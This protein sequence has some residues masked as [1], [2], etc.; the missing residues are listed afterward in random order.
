MKKK[1]TYKDIKN[2]KEH[3]ILS[4]VLFVIVFIIFL[5]SYKAFLE[6]IGTTDE[7]AYVE[8]SSNISFN[9]DTLN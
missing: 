5:F 6:R 8:Q 3:P 9:D 1:E 7:K 2:K 4:S